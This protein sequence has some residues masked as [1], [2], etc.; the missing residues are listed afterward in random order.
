[1]S[2]IGFLGFLGNLS[3]LYSRSMQSWT[4]QQLALLRSRYPDW[5]LWT[6]RSIYPKP[7]TTWCARPTGTAVAT[8]NADSPEALIAEIREQETA[9]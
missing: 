4:D 6:V 7:S 9:Q 2:G 8:I 1:M 3:S 5:D